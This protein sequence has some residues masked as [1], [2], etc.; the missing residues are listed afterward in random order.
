MRILDVH[1]Y[2]ARIQP[3]SPIVPNCDLAKLFSS[4]RLPRDIV[5]DIMHME[6]FRIAAV[7]RVRIN[8][9]SRGDNVILHP[10]VA[11]YA[12]EIIPLSVNVMC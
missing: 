1:T 11:I 2:I 6:Q 5:H 8:F 7:I 12:I 9:A 10:L 4:T 3:E